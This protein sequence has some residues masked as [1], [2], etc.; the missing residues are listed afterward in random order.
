MEDKPGDAFTLLDVRQ[1]G[2]YE[3]GHLPGATLIPL[4]DLGERL[5]EI[6]SKKP[7]I[8]YCA[9]GGRSRMAAQMLAG[10]GF[11]EVYN[12]SGGIK[13]WDSNTAVGPQDEGLALFSGR[14]NIQEALTIAYSLEAGLQDFYL[15]MA[16]KG[17]TSKVQKL[18]HALAKIETQHQD[19]LYGIYQSLTES[20]LSRSAFEAQTETDMVEGGLTTEAYLA[21]FQPDLS[22]TVEVISLAMSIEAQALDLYQRAARNC[23]DSASKKAFMQI[24]NEEKAHLKQ[25]GHLMERRE[26]A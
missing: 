6:D 5:G 14:E 11:D 10:K 1:P 9:I 25:L 2:E 23:D 22:S 13:A 19:H 3:E 12:L 16:P 20:P 26:T 18:F 17:L 7:T 21:Q 4:P 24:A 8:V 15:A